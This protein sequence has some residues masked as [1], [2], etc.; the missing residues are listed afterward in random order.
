MKVTVEIELNDD[1]WK[2]EYETCCQELFMED[3]FSNWD[4][5]GVENVKLTKVEK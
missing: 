4:K 5:G 2:E 1:W 3:L